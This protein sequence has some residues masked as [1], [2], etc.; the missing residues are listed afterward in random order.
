[1][2]T[3]SDIK[4]VPASQEQLSKATVAL[5]PCGDLFEDFFDTIGVSFEILRTEQTGGW[6]FNYIEALQCANVETV[7]IFI[8]A[9]VSEPLRFIHE[10]TG[11]VICI[12]PSPRLHRIFRWITQSK[13]FPNKAV[14]RS[15][16]SYFVLPLQ[17]LTQELQQ[18]EH[19]AIL[20]QDYENPS[21]DVCVLLGK[22]LRL[23]VFATFQGGTSPRSKLEH[24]IRPST[25]RACTGL[26]IG[27]GVENQRVQTRYQVPVNKIARIFNPMDVLGWQPLDR[28]EARLAL[29]ISPTARVV[30]CHGRINI[31]H[32]GLDLLLETWQQICCE[33]PNRELC[34]LLV[35]TGEDA[36]KLH[37][38][39]AAMKL[40]TVLWIDQYIR[41]RALLWQYI[42]TADVYVMASRYEGFPVAPIEAMACELPVVAT[43]VPGISDILEGG[44]ASGGFIVP[45]EDTTALAAAL[46]AILDNPEWGRE[47]GKRARRRAKDCFS[48]EAIGQQMREFL[49]SSI[50]QSNHE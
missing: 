48:L 42:S 15:L 32:K 2:L 7:L 46:G 31:Q 41:D 22:F 5:M 47:L 10:P 44:E 39:I 36:P 29:G 4:K 40:E 25:L 1:M 9:K 37:A 33:R 27:S 3:S 12:L 43:D 17:W 28:K 45:R 26:I 13:L 49:F 14:I 50:S 18:Y 21:F 38:Q 8:S 11:A 23:P 6:M 34:L 35:G 24:L 16:D 19:C 20:F 30:I